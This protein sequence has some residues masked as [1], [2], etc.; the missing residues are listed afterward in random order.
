VIAAPGILAPHGEYEEAWLAFCRM[1]CG[2]GR[3]P[4]IEEQESAVATATVA[5][6]PKPTFSQSY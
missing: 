2:F 4:R 1:P 5:R 6:D 3:Q